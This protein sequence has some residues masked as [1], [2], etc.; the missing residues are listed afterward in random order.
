MSFSVKHTNC[1]TELSPVGRQLWLALNHMDDFNFNNIDEAPTWQEITK[2]IEHKKISVVGI[3][4]RVTAH[5]CGM[6]V[7]FFLTQYNEPYPILKLSPHVATRWIFPNWPE[8]YSHV[9]ICWMCWKYGCGIIIP[10]LKCAFIRFCK[11][12]PEFYANYKN[13]WSINKIIPIL[14]ILTSVDWKHLHNIMCDSI[15]LFN[16]LMVC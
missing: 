4:R 13:I 14:W 6:T 16:K 8:F 2:F 10:Q 9:T 12:F 3:P 1:S 7:V 11:I 5:T 15:A